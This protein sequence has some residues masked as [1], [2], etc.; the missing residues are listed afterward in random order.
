MAG[1]RLTIDLDDRAVQRRLAEML[2]RGQ[3]LEPVFADIGE[4]LDLAHRERF[5]REID[6]QGDAW[7][8]LAEKTIERK[9]KKGRD[10][11]IL[12][13]T[14][15]LRDLLRYQI[16]DDALEFGTDRIYGATQQFGDEDRGIPAREW[17][18]FSRED[19]KEISD[20]I[21]DW[22]AGE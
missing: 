18:G 15:D 11:G 20:I 14:G 22:L 16:S 7:E 13:E 9:R 17:L 1:A 5:D 10:G 4:Y 3:N 19:M 8:P 2:R 12:V 21:A 6:P